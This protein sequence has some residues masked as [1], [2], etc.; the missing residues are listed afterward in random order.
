[1]PSVGLAVI[2]Q[3]MRLTP[4]TP[5][6]SALPGRLFRDPGRIDYVEIPY[7]A[8]ALPAI[9]AWLVGSSS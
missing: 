8:A 3:A 1:M 5:M 6:R 4:L 7:T 2:K 9:T